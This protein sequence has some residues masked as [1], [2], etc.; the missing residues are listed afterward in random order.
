MLSSTPTS[1][2]IT[3]SHRLIAGGQEKRILSSI[4]R[5]PLLGRVIGLLLRELN[6][7][8]L[9]HGQE[10]P[11]QSDVDSDAGELVAGAGAERAGAARATE[12]ADQAAA[13]A[14]LDQY[15][16]DQKQ[17]DGKNEEIQQAGNDTHVHIS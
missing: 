6:H 2:G 17:A 13:F 4:F 10:Q 14:A 1:W 9:G 16:Q 5:R 15:E 3:E 7:F 11:K 12:G 8:H